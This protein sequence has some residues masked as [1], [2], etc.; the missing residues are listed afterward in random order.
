M[1]VWMQGRFFFVGSVGMTI[2]LCNVVVTGRNSGL[3]VMW[4]M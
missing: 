3:A 4:L 1:A 2:Y